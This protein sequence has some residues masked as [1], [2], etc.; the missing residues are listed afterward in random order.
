MLKQTQSL[1]FI[2]G[3]LLEENLET[4]QPTGAKVSFSLVK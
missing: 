3:E 2:L 4:K 1:F